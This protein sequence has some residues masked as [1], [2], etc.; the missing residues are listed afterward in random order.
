M[1][2]D[3]TVVIR[4][5][6]YHRV[7]VLLCD[8]LYG[9]LVEVLGLIVGYLLSVYAQ[10]LCEVAVAV[11]EAYGGHVDTRVGCFFDIVACEHTETAGIDLKAVAEAVLHG[12]IGYGRNVLAHG[13]C[14]VFLEH[15]PYVVDAR[16]HV[17]VGHD[18]LK[19]L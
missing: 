19:T 17:L 10:G 12:E 3:D 5:F 13:L 11:E 14:H 9:E 18:L 16:H 6:K 7:S 2:V 15:L 1:A 4:H 8:L